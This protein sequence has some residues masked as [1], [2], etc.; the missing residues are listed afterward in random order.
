MTILTRSAA[1]LSSFNPEKRTV[2]AVLATETPVRRRSNGSEYD[3]VLAVSRDA[4]DTSRIDGM[5][6]LDSHDNFGL[7][8]RIGS[9]VTG[10]LRFVGTEALVTIKL[11]RN[12]KGEQVFRD[13]ED[14]HTLSVSVGYSISQTET[15]EAARGGISTVRAT[16]WQPQELS[17][18]SVPADPKAKTRS[19]EGSMTIENDNEQRHRPNNIIHERKRVKDIRDLARTA[20]LDSDDELV[21]RAMDDGTDVETFRS[22]VFDKLI[23][24]QERAPTFPH[25]E[26]RGM[27]EDVNRAD[28]MAHA[29]LAR[30]NPAHSA[31][32][33]ARQYMGLPVSEVARRCL[34]DRGTATYGLSPS[35]VITR[36]LH[37]TSD[38]PVILAN[39]LHQQ[40]QAAYKS[41]PSSLKQVAR[42]SSAVDFR[43]KTL[44]KMS[45]GPGLEKVNEHG[46]FKRGSFSEASESYKLTTFGKVFGVTRQLLIN[47]QLGAFA[48]AASKLG[49]TAEAFEAQFLANLLESNPVMGDSKALFHADHKNVAATGTAISADALSAARLAMRKQVG[50]AGELISVTP[51]YLIVPPDLETKAEQVLATIA[52]AKTDDVNPFSGS[53]RLIVEPRLTDAKAWYLAASPSEID[54]LEYSYLAGEPGPQI[55]TNPQFNVD[56]VEY[57]VRLDYGAAFVEHRGWYRNPGA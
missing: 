33:E 24:R 14:G 51:A 9:V 45:S 4:I 2:D 52:A 5:A 46:E 26:T 54:G 31:P 55:E 12:A 16:R 8:S 25:V 50:L 30:I 44:V 42:E 27:D 15:V 10:S 53:L 3:E 47:D 48:D 40:M 6:V 13:L 29:L 11:S 32:P 36:A 37:T 49:R 34:E 21:R 20:K 7:D 23:A 22:Q 28:A 35:G 43:P 1:R 17:V 41:V 39:V 18:V 56:G 38:F 57:R 19:Q